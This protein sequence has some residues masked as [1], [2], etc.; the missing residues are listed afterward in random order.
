MT[1]LAGNVRLCVAFLAGLLVLS[2][3]ASA[4]GRG[5]QSDGG[6][7]AED[8]VVLY[9]SDD[10]VMWAAI[11]KARE[12]LDEFWGRFEKPT[13]DVG[14]FALKVAISD[15]DQATVEHMWVGALERKDDGVIEGTINNEPNHLKSVKFGQRYRFKSEQISDWM[16]YRRGKIVGG[17]TIRP[18]LERLPAERA[19]A[20]RRMLETP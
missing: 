19:N 11:A 6:G 3:G 14:R 13:P 7:N 16:F 10:P 8:K 15:P 12:T 1:L 5:G 17:Y 20:I 2:M 4:E 9:P 18:M